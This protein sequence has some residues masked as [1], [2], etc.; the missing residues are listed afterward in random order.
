[1]VKALKMNTISFLSCASS[2]FPG[3]LRPLKGGRVRISGLRVV[4]AVK[5]PYAAPG[6]HYWSGQPGIR[7]YATDFHA[8][9]LTPDQ[10]MKSAQLEEARDE[11][12]RDT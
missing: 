1:M 6:R 10:H 5:Q 11:C 7:G 3:F 12:S 9:S 2:S 4:I 8:S